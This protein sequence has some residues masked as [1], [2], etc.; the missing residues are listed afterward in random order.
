MFSHKYPFS[1][2]ISLII[3]KCNDVPYIPPGTKK[4]KYI[5]ES[6][7]CVCIL[8]HVYYPEQ[9]FAFRHPLWSCLVNCAPDAPEFAYLI[10]AIFSDKKEIEVV[11]NLSGTNAQ[12]FIDRL[13]KV[14]LSQPWSQK[15]IPANSNSKS[16]VI[17]GSGASKT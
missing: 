5:E 6:L 1:L 11:Q 12:A 15:T 8:D 17:K 3:K 2:L 7:M 16:N 14:S 9:F 4:A 10:T 13:D